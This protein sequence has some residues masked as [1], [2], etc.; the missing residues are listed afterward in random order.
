MLA[1]YNLYRSL[2][3]ILLSFLTKNIV[4][5]LTFFRQQYSS[6]EYQVVCGVWI[7]NFISFKLKSKILAHRLSNLWPRYW[8]KKPIYKNIK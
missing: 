2:F 4:I 1:K 3:D 7:A 6:N 5:K 8:E